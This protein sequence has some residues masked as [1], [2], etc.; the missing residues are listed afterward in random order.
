VVCD[1]ALAANIPRIG[2]VQNIDRNS[3]LPAC[4]GGMKRRV[5]AKPE[6]APEPNNRRYIA[7]PDS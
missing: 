2:I 7:T 5:V 3:R 1:S 4:D 6:I